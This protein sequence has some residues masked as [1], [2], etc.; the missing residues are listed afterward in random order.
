MT[1][2]WKVDEFYDFNTKI[3]KNSKNPK[4]KG[5]AIVLLTLFSIASIYNQI[6]FCSNWLWMGESL[7][8]L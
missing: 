4:T 5:I 1:V 2:S 7:I 6:F 8:I 3:L